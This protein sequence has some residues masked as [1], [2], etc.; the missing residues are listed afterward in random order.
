MKIVHKEWGHEI[1]V[2]NEDKYC[3]KYLII[4]PGKQC[5]LHYHPIKKET[6]YVE[7]GV[8]HVQ[9][10]H[11]IGDFKEGGQVT[12]DPRTPHRFGSE[13]GARIIEISTHHEDDDVVRL[14]L[15]GDFT[16]EDWK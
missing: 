2:V 9:V 15:S 3:M 1:W 7:E 5:S 12:I 16:P 11:L 10:S 13:D 8:V 14:E 6:F 4:D